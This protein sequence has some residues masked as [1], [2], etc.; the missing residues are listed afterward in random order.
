MDINQEIK[1]AWKQNRE[2]A[3][4]YHQII[5]RF[6]QI[7]GNPSNCTKTIEYDISNN[8]HVISLHDYHE[9]YVKT[10]EIPYDAIAQLSED[11]IDY[12]CKIALMYRL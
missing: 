1:T 3:E 5:Q 4:R 7:A 12:I 9:D 10:I 8:I 2:K 6:I 11:Q